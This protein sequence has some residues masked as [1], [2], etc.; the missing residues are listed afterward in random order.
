MDNM[1]ARSRYIRRSTVNRKKKRSEKEKTLS[2]TLSRQTAMAILIL[3]AVFLIKSINLPVTN[4]LSE[5]VR[6]TVSYNI[7]IKNIY[8]S[9]DEFL[10]KI[11]GDK[12]FGDNKGGDE[13]RTETASI[14]IADH[15]ISNDVNLS[16]RNFA[17]PL[18]GEVVSPF[19]NIIHPIKETKQF[20]GGIDIE[21][22]SDW[23]VKSALDGVVLEIGSEKTYGMYIKI[24]HDGL[25]TVYAHCSEIIVKEEQKIA[26]GDVIASIGDENDFIGSHLHFEVWKNGKPVDPSNYIQLPLKEQ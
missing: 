4:F 7:E 21:S 17:V 2:R 19:G 1:A 8:K 6:E 16:D 22:N 14:G 20:H 26:K 11:L 24:L 25:I 13:Q 9:I 15:D 18:N 5:K 10:S 3:A 23:L 12:L